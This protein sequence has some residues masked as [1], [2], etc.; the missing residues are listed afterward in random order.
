MTTAATPAVAKDA[1]FAYYGVS[2]SEN[3]CK[4]P[5]GFVIAK[6]AVIGRTGA[7]K[8]PISALNRAQLSDLGIAGKYGAYD[9]VDVYRD[10]EEVF[11]P[12]T[13]ASFEGAP[14]TDNHPREFVTAKNI[15]DHHRGHVQN[16][17]RGTDPLATGE[18]PILADI[19][20]MDADLAEEVLSRRKRELSCGYNYHLAYDGQR[21]SQVGITGNHVAVV[22][23]GRAGAEARINDSA[24]PRKEYPVMAKDTLIGLGLA[25]MA[26]DNADP[27]KV[28]E[29][30]RAAFATDAAA[31]AKDAATAALEAKDAEIATLKSELAAL[32][33]KD[34]E[35]DEDD[36]KEKDKEKGEDADLAA[37]LAA[38]GA[39]EDDEDEDDEEKKDKGEDAEFIEPIGEAP[40]SDLRTMLRKLRPAIARSNDAALKARFNKLVARANDGLKGKDGSTPS[41]SYSQ[42]RKASGQASQEARDSQ[43]VMSD[44]V[45]R[46]N[47]RAHKRFSGEEK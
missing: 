19:H 21:L 7:Q 27:D 35:K 14:L 42:F 43:S 47:E 34:A 40:V 17:R 33:A 31:P 44:A 38:L 46:L 39:D 15:S 1:A 25:A 10:P 20:I 28:A 26:R 3:I 13:L 30:A 41:D 29:A 24:P 5:Q 2:L 8:Y 6:D 12:A 32:K 22:A 11:S 4:T 37:Q 18:Y 45:K 36:E 9:V 16:V 23:R